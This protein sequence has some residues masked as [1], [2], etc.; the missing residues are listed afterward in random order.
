[1]LPDVAA[2]WA[3]AGAREGVAL[4]LT[5]RARSSVASARPECGPFP[6]GLVAFRPAVEI[7][8]GQRLMPILTE[9]GIELA[10]EPE[11]LEIHNIIRR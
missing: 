9:V 4:S 10:G 2:S 1:V 5:S 11:L 8:F 7:A 3:S 6:R